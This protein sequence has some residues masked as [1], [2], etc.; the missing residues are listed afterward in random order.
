M[1]NT[2]ITQPQGSN[3]K[4]LVIGG[5]VAV[6][7]IGAGIYLFT[8]N[9]SLYKGTVPGTLG[10]L[11]NLNA[12][13]ANLNEAAQLPPASAVEEEAPVADSPAQPAVNADAVNNALNEGAALP[14]SPAD[15][16]PVS[17]KAEA[18]SVSAAQASGNNGLS[19]NLGAL[20]AGNHNADAN[21]AAV[22]AL[23]QANQV[24][25]A[26]LELLN[27][28]AQPAASVQNLDGGLA[29]TPGALAG[30]QAL[31]LKPGALP[32]AQAAA[33]APAAPAVNGGKLG[34]INVSALK[35]APV[36]PN[37][38]LKQ[39]EQAPAVAVAQP[40]VDNFGNANSYP[41]Q[42]ETLKRIKELEDALAAQDRARQAASA[43]GDN[44]NQLTPEQA[45]AQ[46]NRLAQ[47][48]AEAR[49][50]QADAMRNAANQPAD[51]Q[52]N[53]KKPLQ[54]GVIDVDAIAQAEA[55]NAALEASNS[56]GEATVTRT[57]RVN[58]AGRTDAAAAGRLH[59]AAIQGTSG[60]E[61]LL[62]PI[63]VAAANGAYFSLRRRANRK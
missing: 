28:Q 36:I 14:V 42:P 49:V 3:K 40:V 61:V 43:Y 47:E 21:Q 25:V 12:P 38:N 11:G 16:A 4:K 7:V 32:G 20:S 50:A 6:A 58:A 41:E 24:P 48:A 23:A 51:N 44:N 31:N 33:D 62:Y 56:A 26:N 13:A 54:G 30:P 39:T 22:P 2:V 9:Q 34:A 37:P 59:G 10:N 18:G 5:V 27:G 19:V 63:L 53:N 8:G 15:V 46:A 55:A 35:N 1:E 17:P 29:A 57:A 60:P 45:A 52:I